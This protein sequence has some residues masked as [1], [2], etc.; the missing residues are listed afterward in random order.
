[1]KLRR[2]LCIMLIVQLVLLPLL[3]VRQWGSRSPL[4][5]PAVVPL[6]RSG[7][8]Q[9]RGC[10][11][12]PDCRL[13]LRRV[14]QFL[15]DWVPASPK[16]RRAMEMAAESFRVNF[17]CS[18]PRTVASFG[19]S[20]YE[21]RS[22]SLFC[23]QTMGK[24]V[25]R[26][27][28]KI[29]FFAL[30][31]NEPEASAFIFDAERDAK[32]WKW[33]WSFPGCA[34]FESRLCNAPALRTFSTGVLREILD[35]ASAASSVGAQIMLEGFALQMLLEHGLAL[36]MQKR[37]EEILRRPK[38]FYPPLSSVDCNGKE[39]NAVAAMHVRRGD[40]CATW[41]DERFWDDHTRPCFTTEL[42]AKELEKL[43]N[44]YGVCEVR[45]ATDDESFLEE[46]PMLAYS[47]GLKFL[48]ANREPLEFLTPKQAAGRP[49]SFIENRGWNFIQKKAIVE[50]FFSDL[51]FLGS[52]DMLL[53]T[54]SST[55]SR[56]LL[57]LIASKTG[58]I[59][60]FISLD[61]PLEHYDD[62]RGSCSL[63][64]WI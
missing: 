55:L 54:L 44:R 36:C 53:G 62:D 12:G 6:L 16:Q 9:C 39:G 19:V 13:D 58:E 22:T 8:L 31:H 21:V 7:F 35:E 20:C 52:A 37:V 49:E 2:A 45:V 41:K 50:S 18:L 15:P 59:P 56:L 46:L 43:R 5:P 32:H 26:W 1:M 60:P 11:Y 17:F 4:Q 24:M 64:E 28:H 48:V 47:L 38:R 10:F 27:M 40:A 51:V 29:L 33:K 63:H 61:K 34:I 57:I 3:L 30:G 25:K 23:E 42:Y 14:T